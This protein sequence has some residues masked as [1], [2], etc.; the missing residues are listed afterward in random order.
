MERMHQLA[1]EIRETFD[2]RGWKIE[3]AVQSDQA[4]GKTRRPQSSMGRALVVDAIEVAIS[5]IGGLGYQIVSGGA[6]DIS[7]LVDG[8][9]RRFR[10]RKAEIDPST[11]G[12]KIL[13]GSDAI[14]TITDAEPDS[15]W[16]A[17]RWVLGYTV[18]DEGL[19]VDIFA[20][21]VLGISEDAVPL[22]QLG[23]VTLLGTGGYATPPS[24]GGFQPPEEDDLGGDFGDGDAD[25]TG[26]ASAG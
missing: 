12:Y 19:V 26:E 7:D 17:E 18:D 21:R 2:E 16:P 11:D 23:P 3:R 24:G 22:L 1:D 4:F 13:A 14:L 15:L 8:A 25:D 10:L 20:A 5:R 6:C 9:D